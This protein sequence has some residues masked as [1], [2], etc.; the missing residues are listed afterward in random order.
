MDPPL[1]VDLLLEPGADPI[2][3]W[4]NVRGS[5]PLPFS[6]YLELMTGLERVVAGVPAQLPETREGRSRGSS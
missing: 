2:G 5:E 4:L 1:H 6:G 3:G